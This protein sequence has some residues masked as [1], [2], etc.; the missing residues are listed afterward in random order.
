VVYMSGGMDAG[1]NAVCMSKL[2]ALTLSPMLV[3]AGLDMPGLHWQL[4]GKHSFVGWW[5]GYRS[6]VGG[7]YCHVPER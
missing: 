5:P 3:Y 7:T 2:A 4:N 6:P 1:I